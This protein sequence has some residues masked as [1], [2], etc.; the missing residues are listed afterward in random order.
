MQD[1]LIENKSTI[2]TVV[3]LVIITLVQY[4]IFVT[5]LDLANL[6]AEVKKEIRE[7]MKELPTNKEL[8]LRINPI[9]ADMQEVKQD[10]KK[11]LNILLERQRALKISTK[12]DVLGLAYNTN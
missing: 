10:L 8:D 12:D 5:P 6:K 1:L 2:V 9:E 4:N 3:V 7:E 11:I